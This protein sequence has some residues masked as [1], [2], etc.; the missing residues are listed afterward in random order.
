VSEP[1][2]ELPHGIITFLLTDI[3]GS[4]KLW[5]LHRAAMGLRSPGM[6]R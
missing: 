2:V 4:T 1:P 5:E 6:R 3:E